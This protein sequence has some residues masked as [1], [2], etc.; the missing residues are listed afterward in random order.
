MRGDGRKDG[1]LR[2]VLVRR[3]QIDGTFA[4]PALLPDVPWL[5]PRLRV[6]WNHSMSLLANLIKGEPF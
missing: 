5:R 2:R 6:L 1:V 4:E 3:L